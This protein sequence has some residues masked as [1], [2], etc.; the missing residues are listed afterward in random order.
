MLARD[1][2]VVHRL[3]ARQ[4]A[5][6]AT[7][8]GAGR[9]QKGAPIDPLV[10]IVLGPKVGASVRRG[11]PLAVLHANDQDRLDRAER[12]LA[13]AYAIAAEAVSPPPLI[14][15]RSHPELH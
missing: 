13:H 1:D 10:G 2:G 6:A 8:L 4:V 9:E 5:A 12:A 15:W 14:H 7:I 3:D 11:Q